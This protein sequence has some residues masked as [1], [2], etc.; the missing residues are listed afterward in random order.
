MARKKAETVEAADAPAAGTPT[1]TP[2]DGSGGTPP[3]AA[4]PKE[5]F[6]AG[7]K[8]RNGKDV[9]GTTYNTEITAE[10]AGPEATIKPVSAAYFDGEAMD[11][12]EV[13]SK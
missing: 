4:T 10:H 5:D 8:L 2:T 7:K 12:Y 9:A 13:Y 11:P 6:K 1:P 3:P